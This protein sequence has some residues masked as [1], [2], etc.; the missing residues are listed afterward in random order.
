MAAI[1]FDS[2]PVPIAESPI[3]RLKQSQ[4]VLVTYKFRNEGGNAITAKLQESADNDTYADI[5]NAITSIV[6]GG[7]QDI[8]ALS[9]QP[10]LQVVTESP[11]GGSYIKLDMAYDGIFLGGNL[12]MM[13]ISEQGADGFPI[14]PT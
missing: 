6:A 8:T 3:L 11:D 9:H 10:Y 7:R 12:D 13:L 4:A 2:L 1:S 14:R 5:S